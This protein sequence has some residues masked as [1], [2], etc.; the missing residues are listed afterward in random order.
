MFSTGVIV[1]E[2]TKEPPILILWAINKLI[3]VLII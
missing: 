1:T 2:T 3:T